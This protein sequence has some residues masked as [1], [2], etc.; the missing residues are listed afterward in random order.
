MRRFLVPPSVAML[1]LAIVGPSFAQ[2]KP[3]A[4][5]KAAEGMIKP[6]P[7]HRLTG[8][9]VSVDAQT[10]TVIVKRTA[11]GKSKDYSFA[12]DKDVAAALAQLKPGEH[13]RVGYIKANG[14]MTAETITELGHAAKK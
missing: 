2:A 12:A 3:E 8:S 7:M 13:V 4:K 1:L 5:P 9:I 11:A 14:Q 10:K 6:A